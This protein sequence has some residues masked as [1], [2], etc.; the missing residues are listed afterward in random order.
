V[1]IKRIGISIVVVV[2]LL[3]IGAFILNRP[4]ITDKYTVPKSF[5]SAT[6]FGTNTAIFSNGSNLATYNYATGKVRVVSSAVGLDTIDTVSVS[7]NHDYIVFHSSQ[8][9]QTGLLANQLSAAG[10]SPTSDYW[11]VY[12][13]QS[14]TFHS[15]PQTVLLA[16]ADNTHIYTLTYDANGSGETITTYQV[17]TMLQSASISIP[18][19][20]N[21]FAIP[22][23]FLLQTP[24]NTVLKTT[25][26]VVN[27]QLF[28]GSVLAGV[29]QDGNTAVAVVTQNGIK[30]LA[31]IDINTG[32]IT[33]ITKDVVSSPV[34][35]SPGTVL[36]ST[37][38]G[39]LYT[40][41]LTTR[42]LV[43]WSLGSELHSLT[44]STL[45]LTALI[46]PEAALVTDTS[47]NV[48]LIGSNLAS[49]S[50]L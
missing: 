6:S 43:G 28:S 36:Y 20:S 40:Y 22:N 3:V 13:T 31:T 17:S 48:Y 4:N 25:N 18:G 44:P 15:L 35:L 1:S 21:F 37:T 32:V 23:G 49:T 12:N 39:K 2:F 27:Q 8:V 19:S 38:K 34:W 42:R 45:N 5:M 10:L 16:K 29:S 30:D 24:N 46:G 26:G 11:W 50:S 33:V 47:G 9:S 7:P 14:N 41:N